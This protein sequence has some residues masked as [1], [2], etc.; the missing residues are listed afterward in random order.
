[1]MTF[2]LKK[3]LNMAFY[4]EMILDDYSEVKKDSNYNELKKYT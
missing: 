2:F 3:E 1:M 4:K